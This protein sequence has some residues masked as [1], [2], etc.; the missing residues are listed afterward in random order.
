MAAKFG[1]FVGEDHGRLPTLYTG[2]LNFIKYPISH[3]LLLILAHC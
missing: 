1:A 3:V 2:Y